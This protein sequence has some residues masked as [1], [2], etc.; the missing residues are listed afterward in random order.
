MVA[1]VGEPR[2]AKQEQEAARAEVTEV[3]PNVLRMQLPISMP[4]LGH[5]NAYALLDERGA[6]IVDPGMPGPRTWSALTRRLADAA[7]T[8]SDVHTVI[9]THS[10]PDHF[11]SAGK[12]TEAAG[13]AE[14]VT[15]SAFRAWFMPHSHADAGD[16]H[17][18]HDVD[19]DD[20]S[21]G[22]PWEGRQPW[23][24]TPRR[25]GPSGIR[26]RLRWQ[27]MRLMGRAVARSRFAPPA[28][29]VRVRNGDVLKLAGREWFAVHTPG[30]TI[31]HLCLHDPES[32]LLLSGDHVLPTIT[33][34]ISG[35]GTGRDPLAL[36]FNSLDT[37][38]DLDVDLVLP[39]HGH[40]FADLPGRVESIK[41]HHE[42]RLQQLRDVAA[43][44]GPT[45]VVEY[46]R[47]LFRRERWGSMAESETYAHLEHL[48][49]AG[50]AVRH[51]RDGELVYEMN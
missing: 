32:G 25:H 24:G 36:F 51:E 41:R 17:E 33:P 15:H 35:L 4:G 37:V 14:V 26:G 21:T 47:H 29:T 28:P 23:G 8:P 42:E 2:K 16:D 19:P 30:H 22:N 34:H 10:H 48:R 1:A 46:S 9:I 12:L 20:L 45:S 11:G 13:G 7:L 44:L 39:A 3:G 50:E 27:A 6:A 18:I 49:I 38:G 40:P 31:D 5:V 43:A